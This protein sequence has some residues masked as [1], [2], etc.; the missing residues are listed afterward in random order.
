[1]NG[2]V[3]G[4]AG[5]TM[6]FFYGRLGSKLEGRSQLFAG[7][8]VKGVDGLACRPEVKGRDVWRK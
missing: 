3:E 6:A 5:F 4:K 7:G 2:K 8:A 1:M